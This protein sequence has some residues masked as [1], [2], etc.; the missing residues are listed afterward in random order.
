MTVPEEG[1]W[2]LRVFIFPFRAG[3]ALWPQL[4]CCCHPCAEPKAGSHQ[5]FAPQLSSKES[6]KHHEMR[7]WKPSS[8]SAL[9][10]NYLI[11]KN[12]K[13]CWQSSWDPVPQDT[14]LTYGVPQL[15]PGSL[16][17]F[18]S[19][20]ALVPLQANLWHVLKCFQ[21]T[22]RSKGH[23]NCK[24]PSIFWQMQWKKILHGLYKV[25]SVCRNAPRT[26]VWETPKIWLCISK[27]FFALIELW[28]HWV[29]SQPFS[30][31]AAVHRQEKKR[32]HLIC[33]RAQQPWL[34][35]SPVCSHSTNP[36]RSS[37]ME[38]KCWV[39]AAATEQNLKDKLSFWA[40]NAAASTIPTKMR[41]SEF[42]PKERAGGRRDA[43]G[44][45][46]SP[47]SKRSFEMAK[48][49]ARQGSTQIRKYVGKYTGVGIFKINLFM[50]FV[51]LHYQKRG[52]KY[53]LMGWLKRWIYECIPDKTHSGRL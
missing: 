14:A 44:N 26:R 52:F 8:C 48:V 17:I 42:C 32:K 28:Q 40:K 21:R 23:E 36:H 37:P 39:P 34:L 3:A 6:T 22:L 4:L 53:K 47:H 12:A 35:T 29:R 20:L 5:G 31:S 2:S 24:A 19:S 7:P 13:S 49:R 45:I 51:Q 9:I 38:W 18:S 15:G 11:L 16:G 27:A 30:S 43:D 41:F 46:Q 50:L 1:K 25:R 10:S 33:S